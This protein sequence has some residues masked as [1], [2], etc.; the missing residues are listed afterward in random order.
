VSLLIVVL[1]SAAILGVTCVV[2][3]GLLVRLLRLDPE[4]RTPA[5]ELREDR[6]YVPIA[7]KFLITQHFPAIAAAG[8]IVGPILATLWFGWVPALAWILI[9]CIFISGVLDMASLVA[10]VRHKARSIA[11]VLREYMTRPHIYCSLCSSG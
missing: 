2:Y 8:P 1:V 6:D 7:P 9:G 4:A 10:S 5:V 3:G 11:E